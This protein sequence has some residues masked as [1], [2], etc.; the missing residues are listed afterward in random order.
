MIERQERIHLESG[1]QA[2]QA[3]LFVQKANQFHSYV[4]IEFNGKKGNAKSIMSVMTLALH[5]NSLV[6]LTAHGDDE[7]YA[8]E[9]LT[10]F[11]KSKK[12]D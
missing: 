6:R 8:L 1:L 11:I 10:A 4:S 7:K 9:T 12:I 2:R 3:K 5:Q